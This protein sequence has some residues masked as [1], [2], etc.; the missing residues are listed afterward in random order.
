MR[1][2]YQYANKRGDRFADMVSDQDADTQ[3]YGLNHF[4][5]LGDIADFKA[6][7]V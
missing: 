7:N 2:L 1:I 5:D 3:L 6:I 4:K